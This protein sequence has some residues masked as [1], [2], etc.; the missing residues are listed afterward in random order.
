MGQIKDLSLKL[1]SME[2][3]T[4]TLFLEWCMELNDGVY[5]EGGVTWSRLN[6]LL[7]I[8]L[9]FFLIAIVVRFC[10][11]GCCCPLVINY[12]SFSHD[13]EV[14]GGELQSGRV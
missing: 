10:L 11:V 6:W 8:M 12:S 7:Y 1:L 4:F 3:A 14:S 9:Q 13:R 5:R 2:L